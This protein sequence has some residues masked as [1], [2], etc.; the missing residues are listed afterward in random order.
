MEDQYDVD[1]GN[2]LESATFNISLSDMK[3]RRDAAQQEADN[4]TQLIDDLEAL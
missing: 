4:L 3:G 2:K 1:T